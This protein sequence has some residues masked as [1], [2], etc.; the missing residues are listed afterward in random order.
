MKLFSKRL[1]AA[2]VGGF[3]SNYFVTALFLLLEQKNIS[4]SKKYLPVSGIST[5]ANWEKKVQL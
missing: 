2:I 1:Q 4:F 3:T 5:R